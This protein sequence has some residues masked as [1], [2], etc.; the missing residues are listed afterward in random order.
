MGRVP[1]PHRSVPAGELR[2]GAGGSGLRGAG[3]PPPEQKGQGGCRRD[4]AR[5]DPTR[6]VPGM[7]VSR[8][9]PPAGCPEAGRNA[10]GV[11]SQPAG[12]V[13][14]KT[15]PSPGGNRAEPGGRPEPSRD[16]VGDFGGGG[17]PPPPLAL[18]PLLNGGGQARR[19]ARRSPQPR[20]FLFHA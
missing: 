11:P 10:P 15:A 5:P 4:G 20:C 2:P 16:W 17:T 6:G 13:H 1:A 19:G 12:A 3:V 9:S 7:G 18:S 8:E 14:G